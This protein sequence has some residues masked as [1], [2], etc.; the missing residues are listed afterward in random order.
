MND[1]SKMELYVIERERCVDVL[2]QDTEKQNRKEIE[3]N[4]FETDDDGDDDVNVWRA[5]EGTKKKEAREKA[6]SK[7]FC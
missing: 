6:N 7:R 2:L 4:Q 3:S 5:K 1:E